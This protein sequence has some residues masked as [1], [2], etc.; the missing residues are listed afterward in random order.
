[1][2]FERIKNFIFASI[3]NIDYD[4]S[5]GE[6]L[7]SSKVD[8]AYIA[9]V[10]LAAFIATL[11]LIA[12]SAAVIIGAMIISPIMSPIMLSGASFAIMDK[13][14]AKSPVFA[15]IVGVAGALRSE[16]EDFKR[17]RRGGD[18]GCANAAALC[19]GLRSCYRLGFN[20][21]WRILDVFSEYGSHIRG[22][23][24]H[25][26]PLWLFILF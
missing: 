5:I 8:F 12:N 19:G 18:T 4:K 20:R 3:G 15:V 1:M 11:G 24:C 22:C 26:I 6:L 23:F 13:T 17:R 10:V 25:S 21:T 14:K 7:E 16:R 2:Y 9:L